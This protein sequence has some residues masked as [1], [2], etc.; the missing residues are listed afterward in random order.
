MGI[1]TIVNL[2]TD[3]EMDLRDWKLDQVQVFCNRQQVKYIRLPMKDLLEDEYCFELF[4]AAKELNKI[5]SP[6][7]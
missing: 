7:S 2:L 6:N 4:S 5:L 3:E 1:K